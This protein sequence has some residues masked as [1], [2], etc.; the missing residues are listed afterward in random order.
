MVVMK[1][2]VK[3]AADVVSLFSLLTFFLFVR[4]RARRFFVCLLEVEVI[5]FFAH[6]TLFFFSLSLSVCLFFPSRFAYLVCI[7]F[8]IL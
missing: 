3:I 2:I 8:L 7:F 4:L 6:R 1:T 5:Y